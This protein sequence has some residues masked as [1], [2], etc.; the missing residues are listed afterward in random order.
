MEAPVV[1]GIGLY[2]VDGPVGIVI[3]EVFVKRRI[4]EKGVDHQRTQVLKEE[5]G[6]VQD[7]WAQVLKYNS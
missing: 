4:V 5:E 1:H 6:A 7:L 3:A 2:R